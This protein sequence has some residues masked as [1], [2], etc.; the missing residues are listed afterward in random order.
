MNFLKKVVLPIF[1]ASIWISL[2]EFV[3]N[4]VLLKH[5]WT[6]HYESLGLVFPSE[7]INGAIWGIWSFLFAIAIY[8]ISTKFSLL[9]TTLLSWFVGFILMWLVAGNLGVLPLAILYVAIPL[10]LMEVFLA[11]I[12]IIRTSNNH[13]SP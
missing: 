1:L 5:Y 6:N 7:P 11:T 13:K 10:S 12:I 9:K 4:E 2:S 8:L 3:R